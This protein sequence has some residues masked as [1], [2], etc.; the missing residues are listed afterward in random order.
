MLYFC[1]HAS[2][3]IWNQQQWRHSSTFFWSSSWCLTNW[4]CNLFRTPQWTPCI[5]S[6]RSPTPCRS[7]SLWTGSRMWRV[8]FD[9]VCKD[10]L[11]I[12]SRNCDRGKESKAIRISLRG[13][14]SDRPFFL[15][16]ALDLLCIF[17][18]FSDQ[19]PSHAQWEEDYQWLSYPS[20]LPYWAALRS[21]DCLHPSVIFCKNL[22][23]TLEVPSRG[24]KCA[25]GR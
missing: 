13:C 19:F 7:S 17:G 23:R 15:F 8:V 5:L 12:W 3:G 18:R 4:F 24:H 25:V 11:P 14:I 10:Y 16:L 22:Q 1:H 6:A 2:Q 21:K 20:T 9:R